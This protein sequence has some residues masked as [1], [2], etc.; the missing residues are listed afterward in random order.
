[1]RE[2]VKSWITE[3][4]LKRLAL[5]DAVDIEVRPLKQGY[6]EDKELESSTE[7]EAKFS[8]P[9]TRSAENGR[10]PMGPNGT[11]PGENGDSVKKALAAAAQ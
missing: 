10:P 3:W 4:D 7:E 6:R 2:Y 1:M 11:H 8:A 5:G 9:E